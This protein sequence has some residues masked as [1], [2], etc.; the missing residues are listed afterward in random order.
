MIV[1]FVVDTSPTMAL[2]INKEQQGTNNGMSRLDLAKMVI[3]SQLT[4]STQI[5]IS[6]PPQKGRF[7]KRIRQTYNRIQQTTTRFLTASRPILIIID[8]STRYK[9]TRNHNLWSRW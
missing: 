1:V 8:Q 9:P 4:Q 5:S 7:R 6:R 3:V 2:P